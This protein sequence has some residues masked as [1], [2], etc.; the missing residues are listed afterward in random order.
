MKLR[1][2]LFILALGAACLS[3]PSLRADDNPQA[4][5]DGLRCAVE[6]NDQPPREGPAKL[7]CQILDDFDPLRIVRSRLRH[8]A[9]DSSSDTLPLRARAN[10]NRSFNEFRIS[11]SP[12]TR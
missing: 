11:A 1:R 2:C 3:S 12:P 7:F 5:V 9:T 8:S 10:R 6:S 4:H